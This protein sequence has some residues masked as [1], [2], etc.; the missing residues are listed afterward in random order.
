MD[1]IWHL[2][3]HLLRFNTVIFHMPDA[4]QSFV[5][6]H[7]TVADRHLDIGANIKGQYLISTIEEGLEIPTYNT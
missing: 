3:R 1:I 4:T 2:Y 6:Y 5:Y 7:G